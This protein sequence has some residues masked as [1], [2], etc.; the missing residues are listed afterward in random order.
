MDDLARDLAMAL[1]DS[2]RAATIATMAVADHRRLC[3]KR[4]YKKRRASGVGVCQGT[5]GRS[6]GGGNRSE[7]S[8]SSLDEALLRG[9]V[10]SFAP[11]TRFFSEYPLLG[12]LYFNA[13][14]P[15]VT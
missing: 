13:L 12:R 14:L 8:E 9:Y 11:G 5:R 3:K 2:S 15:E 1:D 6:G 4:R 10:E 7:A